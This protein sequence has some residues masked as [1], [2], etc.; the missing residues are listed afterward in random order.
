MERGGDNTVTM[1]SLVARARLLAASTGLPEW[2]CQYH[3]AWSG[4]TT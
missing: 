1:R 4:M 3:C 2:T